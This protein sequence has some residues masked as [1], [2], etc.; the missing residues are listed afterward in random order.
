MIATLLLFQIA[1][2]FLMMALGFLLVKAHLL[3]AEDSRVLSVI[4]IYLV[5]P[6]VILKSF[7]IEFTEEIRNGFLL[8]VGVAVAVNFVL[9]ALT[10]LYAKWLGLNPVERASI[11]YGNTGNL[12]VPLVMSVLGDEWVIYASAFMFVQLVFLWTHANCLIGGGRGISWKK[13]FTNVNLIAVAVGLLLLVAG[14]RLP[15]LLLET[16]GQL[17]GTVG[18]LSMMMIG[19]LLADVNWKR[20]L[21]GKRLYFVTALKMAV[22]PLL[23]LALFKCSGLAGWVPEGKTILYISFMAVITPSA[24]MVTQLAQLHRTDPAYAG[25]INVMTTL[26]CIA[27]MP[28]MTW[29][30]MAWI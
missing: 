25:A 6:C 18:P 4:V 16:F 26:V 19:M 10:R 24:A 2:L 27:T 3:K 13:L 11:M 15:P 23:I 21:T 22:T 30:Y 12:I 1:A 14:I 9:M 7:Q 5:I 28:L 17:S 20:V 29:L 8:A